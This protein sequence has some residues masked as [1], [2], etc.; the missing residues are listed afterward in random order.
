MDN[1]STPVAAEDK[2]PLH[3]VSDK[4]RFIRLC[5]LIFTSSCAFTFLDTK[6]AFLI[7]TS[8]AI[9][10]GILAFFIKHKLYAALI[11]PVTA[12]CSAFPHF[13]FLIPMLLFMILLAFLCASYLKDRPGQFVFFTMCALMYSLA[14]IG[15]CVLVAIQYFGSVEACLEAITQYSA[16][17]AELLFG[18]IPEWLTANASAEDLATIKEAYLGA[19]GQV[20][21]LIPS[22]LVISSMYAAILTKSTL[23]KALGGKK[24]LPV[25]FS[26]PYYPPLALA[27]VYMIL[28]LFGIIFALSS[29][30][31]YYTYMN[32]MSVLGVIFACIGLAEYVA[33]LKHPVHPKQ[34]TVYVVMGIVVTFF[35]TM[36]AFTILAYYGAY[37]TIF[38]RVRVI[39]I[40]KK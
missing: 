28:S 18:N 2:Q 27:V 26:K 21:Y 11:V 8:F 17:V 40:T 30:E 1:R 15:G 35:F 34:R 22:V 37:R 20:V 7:I 39:R 12:S 24:M 3:P 25:L 6:N 23:T 19:A 4:G 10:T 5:I 38:S 36:S 14:A 13:K 31:A 9:A 16:S 33:V 29:E 32:V